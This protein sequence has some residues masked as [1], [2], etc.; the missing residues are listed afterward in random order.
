MLKVIYQ[1]RRM[2]LRRK[3]LA[4]LLKVNSNLGSSRSVSQ[5]LASG[6]SLFLAQVALQVNN[7]HAES[8]R[9]PC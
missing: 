7:R 9:T 3:A 2:L 1:V 4:C 5:Q 6:K 8:H